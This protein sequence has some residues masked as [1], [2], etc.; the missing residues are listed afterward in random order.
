MVRLEGLEP[1]T[2]WVEASCS[3]PLSYSRISLFIIKT[4]ILSIELTPAKLAPR[5]GLEPGTY[6]LT[7]RRSTD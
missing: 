7:V 5:P 4:V 3:N 1:P 6:G 2:Y